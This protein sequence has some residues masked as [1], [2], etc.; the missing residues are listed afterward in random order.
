MSS[1][2]FDPNRVAEELLNTDARGLKWC[3]YRIDR[4]R[5][6]VFFRNMQRNGLWQTRYV[7]PSQGYRV[8]LA[9]ELVMLSHERERFRRADYR[10]VA[11]QVEPI[12]R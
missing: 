6:L 7:L 12:G 3:L 4:K 2:E 9:E 11:V 1:D 5:R 8:T 10:T